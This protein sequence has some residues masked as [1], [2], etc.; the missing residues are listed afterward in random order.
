MSLVSQ[1]LSIFVMDAEKTTEQ[2][3][4]R[5]LPKIWTDAETRRFL[6]L[7]GCD[8]SEER[9]FAKMKSKH[10]SR[11]RVMKDIA[12]RLNQEGISVTSSQVDNKRKSLLNSYR[13]VEDY[14]SKSGND[15]KK[16]APFHDEIGTIIGDRASTRPKSLAGSSLP[17]VAVVDVDVP[18]IPSTPATP[19]TP[20][21]ATSCSSASSASPSFI[22]SPAKRE[23]LEEDDCEDLGEV[24]SVSIYS[25]PAKKPC[26]SA[27]LAGRA[28]KKAKGEKKSKAVFVPHANK[29]SSRSRTNEVSAFLKSYQA[30]QR[31]A[32][33]K[34]ME[35]TEE[36]HNQKMEIFGR[37]LAVM[38]KK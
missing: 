19:Y 28:N 37:F 11:A 16:D 10:L 29:S 14:N 21:F 27:S 26:T 1:Y 4:G 18:D 23:L 2:S 8:R 17:V 25:P 15:V 35:K 24:E 3:P 12:V 32:E 36:K 6:E 38:E 7:T 13:A 31:E 30:E 20:K 34:R 22:D 33:K 5:V 9:Y